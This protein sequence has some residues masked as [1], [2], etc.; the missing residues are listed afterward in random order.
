MLNQTYE[1]SM[2]G[3][4]EEL[5][6]I[7]KLHADGVLTD[8]EFRNLKAKL[9]RPEASTIIEAANTRVGGNEEN[10]HAKAGGYQRVEKASPW[11]A[12][13]PTDLWSCRDLI[14]STFEKVCIAF[15]LIPT[16]IAILVALVG[17]FGQ[18]PLAGIILAVLTF[19]VT[20]FLA[21][22]ALTLVS[23]AEN[24]REVIRILQMMEKA[25]LGPTA[26]NIRSETR[27]TRE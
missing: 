1:E 16:A 3:L 4:T 24:T 2:P 22:G 7:A 8:E 10:V 5:S 27:P 9:I 12:Y 20:A 26:D 15:V 11:S 21:G 17:L 13:L 14:V 6:R 23:I 25:E 19:L 18:R